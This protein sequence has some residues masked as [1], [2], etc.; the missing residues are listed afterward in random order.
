LRRRSEGAQAI[1]RQLV[2]GHGT[3]AD[4]FLTAPRR[5]RVVLAKLATGAAVGLGAG[6]VTAAAC[7]AAAATMFRLDGTSFPYGDHD[8]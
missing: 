2:G 6:L 1:R 4:T 3:A 5:H 7:L 8:V